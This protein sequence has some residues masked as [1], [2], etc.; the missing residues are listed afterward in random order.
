MRRILLSLVALIGTSIA[1]TVDND[2]FH[3]PE[4]IA[5]E[6]GFKWMEYEVTT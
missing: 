3:T 4:Q 5:S 1:S 2:Q 6:N